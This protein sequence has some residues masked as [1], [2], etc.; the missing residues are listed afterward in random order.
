MR[1]FVPVSLALVAAACSGKPRTPRIRRRRRRPSRR[2]RAGAARAA[3]PPPPMT[4]AQPASSPTGSTTTADPCTDF[5]QYACGGFIKTAE[6]PADRSSGARPIVVK[7][8]SEDFLHEVLEEAA[9]DA[10]R[11]RRR[12]T[13][14]GD[15]YAACMDEA[16]IEKAGDRADPAA[17]R[18]DRQGRPT[19]KSAARSV[20]ALHAVGVLAPFF[21]L[22][23][24]QDFADAT[25][26][27][28]GL[29]Q[30]GLGL[31]DRKYYL[32]N[33][34]TIPKT[35]TAYH[36]HIERMFQLLGL[37]DKARRPP[38]PT[39]SASRPRSRS[40]QQDEVD[41]PRSARDLSPRRAR[42]PRARTRRASRGATTSRRS[43][44]GDGH[45]DHGQRPDV[46]HRRREADRRARSRPRS[47]LPD[48][49]R[50]ARRGAATCRRR[51]STRRSR[52]D[53]ELVGREGAAAALAPLRAP[54][55][56]RPRRAARPV[57]RQGKFAG[58]AKRARSI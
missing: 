13:K 7:K 36:A 38:P 18:R 49:D 58:D 46:L 15:Y 10:A 25:Q 22:G 3:P 41:A 52:C 16:A 45:R 4:L 54:R 23:R 14:I 48:V 40:S 31:P 21:D 33:T 17:A 6:I 37:D 53:K 11:R 27:I 2:G 26:V 51:G 47:A 8:R 43:D 42:R 30:A 12:C 9:T 44:I 28:A 39:R 35:R 20:A 50:A 32:S 5:F 24:R 55:R 57:V 29:D 34:G 1:R 56:R 19:P